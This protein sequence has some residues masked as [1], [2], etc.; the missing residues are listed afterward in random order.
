MK[1]LLSLLLLGTVLSSCSKEDINIPT[2]V[3]EV[4]QGFKLPLPYK[5]R[6][7]IFLDSA[8][9][10]YNVNGVYYDNFG[11][12]T[13]QRLLI[14]QVDTVRTVEV[15]QLEGKIN[16]IKEV[17]VTYNQGQNHRTFNDVA[18]LQL[19]EKSWKRN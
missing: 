16:G 3:K 14:I 10:Y 9:V 15:Y 11:D 2:P 12:T 1:K 5:D 19:N 4:K 17:K 6:V 18:G 8:K 13:S 7:D